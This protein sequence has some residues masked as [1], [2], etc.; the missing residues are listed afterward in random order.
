VTALMDQ[1]ASPTL[2]DTNGETALTAAASGGLNRE[3]LELLLNKGA[4]VKHANRD[5]DTALLI[6]AD[7][8]NR[9]LIEALLEKGADPNAKDSRGNTALI[10]A[11]G[12]RFS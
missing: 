12:T 3:A 1:G 2:V 9:D 7:K 11:A 5:G 4:D 10:R 8:Y 6:A